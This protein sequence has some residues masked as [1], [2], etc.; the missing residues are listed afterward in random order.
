MDRLTAMHVFTEIVDRGSITAAADALEMSRPMVSRHLQSLEQ[1]LG[2][3]LLHRTTRRVSLSEAGQAALAQCRQ[4]LALQAEVQAAAGQQSAEPSGSLRLATAPSFAQAALAGWMVAF[5]ARYPRVRVELLVLDRPVNLVEERIDLAV[6]ITNQLD[7]GLLARQLGACRSV[8][9]AAPTYLA[10]R[11][12]PRTPAELAGH[13]GITHARVS[14]AEI[15]L[16]RARGEGSQRVKAVLPS[17]LQSNETMVTHA[18]ALAGGGVAML[19]RYLVAGDL[20]EGRLL[21][22]LPDWEP[23]VYG[24]HAVYLSRQHTPRPL[25]LMVDFL[26]ERVAQAPW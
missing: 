19:P 11:G 15:T 22:V 3:R 14:R 25:R 26:A 10:R 2:V 5:Q 18:A 1:W 16:T 21:P 7:D 24:I 6:R 23:E 13:A 8:L 9:C 17:T 4:M 12:T 20:A